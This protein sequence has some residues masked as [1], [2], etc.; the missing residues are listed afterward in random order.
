MFSKL[1]AECCNYC[2]GK[3]YAAFFRFV[4]G[5]I[6]HWVAGEMVNKPCLAS[7][8]K[9]CE[10][11]NS[12]VLPGLK[13]KLR[14]SKNILSRARSEKQIDRWQTVALKNMVDND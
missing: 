3:C 14:Y 6:I 5:K 2:G 10:W 11:M 1:T 13:G 12:V 8:G 9:Y 7:R 4:H